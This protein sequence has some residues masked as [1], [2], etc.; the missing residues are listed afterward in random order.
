[1]N[2]G[3]T[4]D[5]FEVNP[6]Y[7]VTLGFSWFVAN[8]G[9]NPWMLGISLEFNTDANGRRWPYAVIYLGTRGYQVGWLWG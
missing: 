2:S 9:R 6:E 4:Y 8:E 1:M 3:F 5:G 7:N